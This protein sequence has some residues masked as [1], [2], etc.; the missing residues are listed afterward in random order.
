MWLGIV[1]PPRLIL[2]KKAETVD[3]QSAWNEFHESTQQPWQTDF[4]SMWLKLVLN[5]SP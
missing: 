5:F 2:G 3:V 4:H 1:H